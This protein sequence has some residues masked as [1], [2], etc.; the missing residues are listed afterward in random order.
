MN[1]LSMGMQHPLGV[2]DLIVFAA[3]AFAV[4]FTVA[5]AVSPGLREWIERPKFRF[6]ES[7]R[8]F[9]EERRP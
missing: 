9:D 8:S 4:I 3:M 2:M 1:M 7:V 5:W 6:Q